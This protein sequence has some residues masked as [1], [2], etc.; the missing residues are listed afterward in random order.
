MCSKQ[1]RRQ[2]NIFNTDLKNL[3]RLKLL[4]VGVCLGLL[5]GIIFSFELWFPLNRTFPRAPVFSALPES[6]VLP[7]E[8]WLGAALVISLMPV[9]FSPRPQIFSLAAVVFLMTLIFFDQT[10]LQP[11][12]YQYLLLLIVFALYDSRAKDESADESAAANQTLA[13][14]QIIIAGLYFWS[15]VQKLNFSFSRETLPAL[16]EN[17]FPSIQLPFLW[18]GLAIALIEALTGV[19]LLFRRTRNAAVCAAVGMHLCILGLLIARNHNSIVWVWN[20]ALIALVIIAFW[21][22][23]AVFGETL[24]KARQLKGKTAMSIAAASVL[25]PILSFWGWCD[26]YLSGALYAGRTETAVI[27]IDDHLL[28]KLPAT[29][30]QSVFQTKTGGEKILPLFEWAIADL[31]VPAYPEARASKQAARE[32]CRLTGD[33]NQIVLIIKQRPAILDGSYK[34]T[35]IG[36]AELESR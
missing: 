21:Q 2:N 33:K 3:M 20:A 10:R 12:I 29:A 17:L 8:R 34:V 25:L 27:R 6:I 30:R 16:I 11:W 1:R 4:R 31:N 24:R 18:L 35:R 9:I 36:C 7:V 23:D 28:A 15:G 13:P 26:S 14:A 19:G 32:V 5:A 22:S